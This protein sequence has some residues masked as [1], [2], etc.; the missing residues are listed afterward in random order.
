MVESNYFY[1]IIII[2]LHRV[3][4]F[5]VFTHNLQ[6]IICFQVIN[7]NNPLFLSLFNFNL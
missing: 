3:E 2:C 6:V 1:L 4:W 5:Q 7:N